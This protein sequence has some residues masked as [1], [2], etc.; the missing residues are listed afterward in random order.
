MH[1]LDWEVGGLAAHPETKAGQVLVV[2]LRALR[3]LMKICDETAR[4]N[5]VIH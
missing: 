1:F 4:N 5:S 2:D 3:S